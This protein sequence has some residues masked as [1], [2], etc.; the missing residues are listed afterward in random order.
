MTK[1]KF[2]FVT[3]ECGDWEAL[4]INGKLAAEGHSVSVRDVLKAISD[5]L[6]NKV[7]RYEIPNEV[8]ENGM[9]ENLKD[10][11]DDLLDY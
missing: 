4:Y 10:L 7:E 6:P 9:P 5:I 8:A 2:T 1:T 3:S 11:S